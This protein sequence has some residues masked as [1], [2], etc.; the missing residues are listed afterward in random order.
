[1]F[2]L[3]QMEWLSNEGVNIGEVLQNYQ[4]I[5]ALLS[6]QDNLLVN[7]FDYAI[8]E[9]TKLFVDIN[10]NQ[11]AN[12]EKVC[13]QVVLLGPNK[14]GVNYHVCKHQSV[15]FIPYIGLYA[16]FDHLF[17]AIKFALKRHHEF[18]NRLQD[19][20]QRKLSQ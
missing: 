13:F 1:M 4:R 17:D 10:D 15:N 9:T 20:R 6:R 7:S 5:Q 11:T 19:S 16:T 18:E 3:A 8:Y 2:N 14:F 12:S